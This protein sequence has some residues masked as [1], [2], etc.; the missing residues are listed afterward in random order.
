MSLVTSVPEN[1]IR[2]NKQNGKELMN[3]KLAC[4]R[5]PDNT[6]ALDLRTRK[7]TS[8]RFNLKLLR[9]FSKRRHLGKL[10]FTFFFFTKNVSR[11]IYSEGG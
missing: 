8:T 5:R 9:V 3:E 10:H 1:K 4:S 2:C 6:E 7:S 11:V